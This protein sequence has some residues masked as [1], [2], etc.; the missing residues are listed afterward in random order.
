MNRDGGDKKEK[1]RN[2]AQHATTLKAVSRLPHI[3]ETDNAT[4]TETYRETGQDAP[5]DVQVSPNVSPLDSRIKNVFFKIKN[6]FHT[7]NWAENDTHTRQQRW[8]ENDTH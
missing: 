8:A 3:L 7:K 6:E 5:E 1:V 4:M 2:S